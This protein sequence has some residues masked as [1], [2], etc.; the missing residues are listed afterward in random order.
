MRGGRE[1]HREE[2]PIGARSEWFNL[3]ILRDRFSE[4]K[5]SASQ[6]KGAVLCQATSLSMSKFG[7]LWVTRS[8]PPRCRVFWRP[9]AADSWF[10]RVPMRPW[11]APGSRTGSS[12]SSSQASSRQRPGTTRPSTR[13]SSRSGKNTPEPASFRSLRVGCRRQGDRKARSL[14]REGRHRL[15]HFERRQFGLLR[16]D[17]CVQS[18]GWP[19]ADDIDRKALFDL[20]VDD[21]RNDNV[22]DLVKVID[23]YRRRKPDP[24]RIWTQVRVER[25]GR[26]LGQD[27]CL[28]LFER[29]LDSRVVKIWFDHV[30]HEFVVV[31]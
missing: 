26:E 27:H 28:E 11:R 23:I 15:R 8:T 7:I 22:R 6:K 19:I 29:C 25:R 16:L 4:E 2:S 14:C 21:S 5:I 3:F 12:C 9:M 31:H 1:A 24:V 20:H 30:G 10:E 13:Q 17:V 18:L